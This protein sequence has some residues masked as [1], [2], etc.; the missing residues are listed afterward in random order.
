MA[1]T[2]P[3]IN[4]LVELAFPPPDSSVVGPEHYENDDFLR[5]ATD[6][7]RTALYHAQPSEVIEHVV[8]PV[9]KHAQRDIQA[10]LEEI[11][12]EPQPIWRGEIPSTAYIWHLLGAF[13]EFMKEHH[14]VLYDQQVEETKAF[15]LLVVKSTVILAAQHQDAPQTV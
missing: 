13:D 3:Q 1:E 2:L 4:S 9:Y 5:A 6:T 10:V 12:T 7:G 14:G 8:T 15:G 11:Y